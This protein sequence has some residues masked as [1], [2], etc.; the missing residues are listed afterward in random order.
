VTPVAKRGGESVT[1]Y[2]AHVD[3]TESLQRCR[4]EALIPRTPRRLLKKRARSGE[5]FWGVRRGR[6][7]VT[8][9]PMYA[10][11]PS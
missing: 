5:V 8:A 3:V 2:D 6:I 1:L 11:Q 10:K 9:K 4:V 7:Y